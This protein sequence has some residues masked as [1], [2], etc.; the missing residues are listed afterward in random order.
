[1]MAK[2]CYDPQEAKSLW[3]RME[4]LGK[5]Q[6]NLAIISTHPTHKDR[7]RN[8]DSWMT[9]AMRRYESAGCNEIKFPF[10]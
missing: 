1:M 6:P 2:A 4:R 9:E 5:K 10:W 7:I 8:I 3:M